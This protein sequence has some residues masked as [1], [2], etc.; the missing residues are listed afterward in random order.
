MSSGDIKGFY[1]QKKKLSG[2]V[3][4]PSS[5]SSKKSKNYKGGASVGASNTAQTPALVTRSGAI[6]LKEEYGE[7]EEALRQFDMDMKYGPCIGVGRLERWER[8]AVMGLDPPWH[9]REVLV[10]LASGSSTAA[11]SKLTCLW[12]GLV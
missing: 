12:E 4:K 9:V 3:T 6:D 11:N 5:S 10:G 7:E 1:R 2:G 8:A